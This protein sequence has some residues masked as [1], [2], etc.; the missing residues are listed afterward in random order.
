MTPED[1]LDEWTSGEKTG[2]RAKRVQRLRQDLKDATGMAIPRRL[3]AIEAIL[4]DPH[5]RGIITR[6][7]KE[8]VKAI[9]E[10]DEDSDEADGGD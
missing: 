8:A 10:A 2:F 7:L 6:K 9:D 5:H 3:S 4:N 1:L